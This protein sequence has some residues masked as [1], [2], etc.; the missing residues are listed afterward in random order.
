MRSG[1]LG[2]LKSKIVTFYPIVVLLV[3][4]ALLVFNNFWN[5]RSFN[6]DANFIVR[7]Q[8][9]SVA[10]SLTPLIE[11]VKEN[12]DIQPTLKSIVDAN[13]DIVEISILEKRLNQ[14]VT[15]ASS[16]SERVG[17][18][19]DI[20]LGD[21][22]LSYRQPFAALVYDPKLQRNIWNVTIPLN[23]ESDKQRV[24]FFVMDTQSIATILD[25]TLH[26]SVVVLVV[27][28]AFTVIL[29]ANHFY[30]YLKALRTK[31][32]EEIDRLKDEFISMAAH[33]LRAPITAITGY[34]ELLRDKIK[35]NRLSETDED[36]G[37]LAKLTKDL[38]DLVEELLNVSRIEQGR[39]KA[40]KRKVQINEIVENVVVVMQPV[41]KG[42]GLNLAFTKGE[43]PVIMTDPDML[44]QVVTN[45]LSNSIK[46]TLTG[47][48]NIESKSEGNFVRVTVK[49]SGIGIPLAEMGKLFTKFHRVQD[50]QTPDVRG[51]GLGLWITKQVVELLGGNIEIQSI[52]GSGT[53]ISFTIPLRI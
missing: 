38:N 51:T 48:I 32:L 50:R 14:F 4:P 5:I 2:V 15:V 8:A 30:F 37:I 34:L 24:L 35:T 49:D 29:L 52:Y 18:N 33:E 13:G 39:L 12:T 19:K 41:A 17:E 44:R 25:R 23:T 1:I 16:E 46:Y 27:L 42:K 7:H 40:D 6:R 31:Q 10:D 47:D 11:S 3:I 36:L 43:I 53:S 21:F 22:S 20:N 28:L 9:V 45:L 26:D